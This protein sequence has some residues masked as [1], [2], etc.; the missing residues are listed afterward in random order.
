VKLS[1]APAGLRV[2]ARTDFLDLSR[3]AETSMIVESA[4]LFGGSPDMR[5]IPMK[6][7]TPVAAG[8]KEMDVPVSLAIPVDALTF[9]PIDGKYKAE[10]ELRVSAV[11]TG[12]NRAPVPVIPV[13]LSA[14]EQPKTGTFVKYD[15]KIRM[16]KM[17]HHLMLALF[18]PLSGKILTAET[19][20]VPPQK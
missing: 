6:L 17:P 2:R 14:D 3:R 19:D 13:A 9:V 10:L 16:R 7:G 8:R 11:D 15:T 4:M 18:D 5:T 1:V 12:G 20:V